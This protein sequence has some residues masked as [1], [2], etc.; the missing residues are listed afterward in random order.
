VEI[1]D[2]IIIEKPQ[3]SVV[4]QVIRLFSLISTDEKR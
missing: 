3:V 4:N 1:K 2:I